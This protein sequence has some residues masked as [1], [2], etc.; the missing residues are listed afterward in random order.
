MTGDHIKIHKQETGLTHSLK[1]NFQIDPQPSSLRVK[2]PRKLFQQMKKH[3]LDN[4]CFLT[5]RFF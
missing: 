5:I 2:L 4:L 3:F 1:D